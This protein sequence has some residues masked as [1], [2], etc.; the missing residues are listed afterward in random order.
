MNQNKSKKIFT[1]LAFLGIYLLSTGVSFA[2]FDYLKKPSEII[3]GKISPEIKEQNLLVDNSGP[4]TEICPLNGALYTKAEKE[5]WTG[6]RPLAVMI[7]NH[8]EARP[9]SGISKADVVYEAVAEGGITR[10]MAVFYCDAIAKENIIGPVRSARTYFLDWAS[11]YGGNP[12]Y[13]HVGGANCSPSSGDG[14][15]NGAKA[16]AL[17][18]I[19]DY[20]WEGENDLNQ[21][22]IGYPTFWRDYERIGHTVATEH[23]M[24]STTERLWAVGKNRG[25]T[26]KDTQGIDWSKNFISWTFKT[27]AKEAERAASNPISFGFWENYDKYNVRWDYDKVNNV[28]KRTNA[29]QPHLDLNN[30]QQLEVKNVVIQF[31]KESPANDGYAGNAH[32]LYGTIGEGKA[33]VFQDGQTIEGK[34]VKKSRLDRT[35]YFTALAKEIKFNPGKIWI[36]TLPIGT[37]ITY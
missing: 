14:C 29:G 10:F 35:K 32:L 31:Q 37:K 27:E 15:L 21:F 20:G 25:Y 34:W 17:G 5:V 23:T 3:G 8:E 6:R 12:L 9:Q 33:L 1:I 24:Y 16:D 28:Y 26:N 18:Q 2:I 11:E 36:E 19:G 13:A 7:E 4:K 30:K 22:S